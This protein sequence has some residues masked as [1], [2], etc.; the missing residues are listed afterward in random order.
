PAFGNAINNHVFEHQKPS[1]KLVQK[2]RLHPVTTR[3]AHLCIVPK[4]AL[5]AAGQTSYYFTERLQ[6]LTQQ[7]H[8]QLTLASSAAECQLMRKN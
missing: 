3:A 7:K 8:E 4:Q 2:F 5:V 1:I 6:N